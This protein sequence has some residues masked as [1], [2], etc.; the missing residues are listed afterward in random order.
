MKSKRF[1]KS[2]FRKTLT[3]VLIT[4]TINLIKNKSN[5]Q[6]VDSINYSLELNDDLSFNDI[7]LLKEEQKVEVVME[8]K[9]AKLKKAIENGTYMVDSNRIANKIIKKSLGS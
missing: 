7:D 6:G 5:P 8:E 9:I 1:L 2:V 4:E 3:T